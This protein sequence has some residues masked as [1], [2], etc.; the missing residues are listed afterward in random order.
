MATCYCMTLRLYNI[1]PSAGFMNNVMT[2]IERS[3]FGSAAQLAEYH[4]L[5]AFT[6]DVI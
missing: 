5:L 6:V 2:L 4:Q 3:R 1:P